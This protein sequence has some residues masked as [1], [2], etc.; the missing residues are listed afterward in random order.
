M[1]MKTHFSCRK[2]VSNVMTVKLIL[3]I[4]CEKHVWYVKLGSMNDLM[5][6]TLPDT[7]SDLAGAG[8]SDLLH[9]TT[10][11]VLVLS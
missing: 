2:Q 11:L 6:S 4:S 3:S 1:W 10:V 9:I 7:T 8:T 5:L